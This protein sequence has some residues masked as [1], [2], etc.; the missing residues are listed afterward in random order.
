MEEKPVYESEMRL[1]DP[2]NGER[3][4][5][6]SKERERFLAASNELANRE[7]RLFCHVLHWTG[8][9]LSEVLE[10]T[11]DR[12]DFEQK[13]IRFR[14][15]KK[16]KKN[17]KGELKKPQFRLVPVTDDLINTLDLLF[18]LRNKKKKNS[19]SMLLPLWGS[20][21]QPDKPISRSTGWRIVK[22]VFKAANIEGPQATTKSLRHGYAVAMIE[23]DMDIY[24]LQRRMGHERPETTSIYLQV[25]GVEAHTLQMKYWERANKDWQTD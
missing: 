25:K 24:T 12:I 14:T 9:R 22:K 5:L 3:L 17:R 18:D 16:K 21:L 20:Q 19:S 1:F 4:Y 23:A 10:L 2:A 7:Y 8:A 15:L 13:A 6:T 11:G